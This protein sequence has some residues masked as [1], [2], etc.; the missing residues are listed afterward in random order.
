MLKWDRMPLTLAGGDEVPGIDRALMDP[1]QSWTRSLPAF[2]A[3]LSES[4]LRHSL[5]ACNLTRHAK[6]VSSFG[7]SMLFGTHHFHSVLQESGC[8]SV[9]DTDA[10]RITWRVNF[11]LSRL[12]DEEIGIPKIEK[13]ADGFV[14]T[15][16]VVDDASIIH[17]QEPVFFGSPVEPD[18]YGMWLIMGLPS[19]YE[20]LRR[21]QEE[22]YLCWLRTD[23]QRK[24]LNF[25]GILEDQIIVQDQWRL[26]DCDSITM[27]QYSHID[28]TPTPSDQM[29]FDIIRERC[30]G[31]QHVSY[32]K[33]FVSRR[34]FTQK[35][36]YRGLLNEDELIEALEYR[37]F[38]TIEPETLD[39]MTQVRIFAS[40]RVVVG[41][42]GAAMFNVIFCRP[43]TAVV[44]IEGSPAFAYGH[45]NMFSTCKLDFGF[46]FGKQDD[47]DPTSVHKRWSI[48]VSEAVRYIDAFI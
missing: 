34:T 27:N 41:L 43:G 19:A 39:F 3:N 33:I 2:V 45:S 29:V 30:M 25:M 26:Y 14:C 11:F 32:E 13:E 10:D 20:F 4:N 15:T 35:V 9:H 44:S 16:N 48:N 36:R 38:V 28:V 37:G 23:W 40:A 12:P 31:E 46:I 1:R 21:R 18:N 24:L 7:R 42:G 22:K 5:F 6:F 8:L 17:V 47:L